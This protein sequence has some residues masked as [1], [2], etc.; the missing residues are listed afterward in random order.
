MSLVALS[1]IINCINSAMTRNGPTPE[2]AVF[3]RSLKFT[4][5]SE[6]DDDQV[7]NVLGSH[8]MA[9]KA[10]QIRTAAKIQLLSWN[11]M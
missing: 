11:S 5:L 9:W 1:A 3:G 4:E 2:Q 8:G 6:T 10:S 7:M